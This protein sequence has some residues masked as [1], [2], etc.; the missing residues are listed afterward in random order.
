[1]DNSEVFQNTLHA[2]ITGDAWLQKVMLDT[3][4]TIISWLDPTSI[5]Q[6]SSAC[7]AFRAAI[8]ND[9]PSW[10]RALR[11]ISTELSLAPK[12]FDG[13]QTT[14]DL[15]RITTRPSRL[16]QAL[17]QPE[18]PLTVK[19]RKY[20]LDYGD[21]IPPW[22]SRRTAPLYLPPKLLPGGRW[23]VSGVVNWAMLSTQLFLW[24]CTQSPSPDVPLRPVAKYMWDGWQPRIIHRDWIQMQF[25]GP[26]S[27]TFGWSLMGNSGRSI[28][29]DAFCIIWSDD[30]NDPPAFSPSGQLLLGRD[31]CLP[32]DDTATPTYQLQGDYLI[33]D[34]I[35]SLFIWNWREGLVGRIDNR[36]HEWGNGKGFLAA[37]LPPD[38]FI[39]P[40][41]VGEILVIEIPK[42]HPVGTPASLEPIRVTP[43][44]SHPFLGKVEGLRFSRIFQL[45]SWKRPSDQPDIT[46]FQ[47]LRSNDTSLF[48]IISLRPK[49]GSSDF[50][51]FTPQTLSTTLLGTPPE[52]FDRMVTVEGV[53]TITLQNLDLEDREDLPDEVETQTIKALF[54]PFADDGT[55]GEST[56]RE[57]DIQYPY[58]TST[59]P[60]GHISR[61]CLVSGT[62][63]IETEMIYASS[64]TQ[65][66]AIAGVGNDAGGTPGIGCSPQPL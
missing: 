3:V 36:Q 39:I 9:R 55:F 29:Y 57:F 19:T 17:K 24:D 34:T 30:G 25:C 4:D 10:I 51:S 26:N 40:H 38:L 15:R 62:A 64:K 53:G 1:M 8:I 14:G 66:V 11:S 59:A 47:S 37:I 23:M 12:S 52:H 42:L 2:T 28:M 33:I 43:I 49:P 5:I 16:I 45:G 65:I 7:K 44:H 20:V 22:S 27:V 13:Q 6:F 50:P 35:Q 61:L 58:P 56:A 48:N 31:I 41:D 63:V 60:S 32:D 54:W 46:V 21:D 18:R